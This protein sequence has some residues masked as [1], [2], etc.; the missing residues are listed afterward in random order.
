MITGSGCP[1]TLHSRRARS[2]SR[3]RISGLS[4]RK[5][6]LIKISTSKSIDVLPASLRAS[7]VYLKIHL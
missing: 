5:R 4:S 1:S 2:P 7:H 3:T 6:G